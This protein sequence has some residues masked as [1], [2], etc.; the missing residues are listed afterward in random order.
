VSAE[1]IFE[2]NEH[3]DGT[4]V[5]LELSGELDLDTVSPVRER[6]AA[7][8]DEGQ[9][10]RLDLDR[11]TFMDSTGIRMLLIACEDAERGDWSF[12]VTRG[13][14][15]VQRVLVAARVSERLPYA[16]SAST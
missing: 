5:V 1:E 16:A 7:L 12:E 3:R 4:T 9:P 11:L 13:S 6:L 8:R 14:E 2:I 15:P 10:V